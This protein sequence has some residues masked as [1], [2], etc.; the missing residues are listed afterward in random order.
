M[1]N[2]T[3]QFGTSRPDSRSIVKLSLTHHEPKRIPLDIGGTPRISGI[4]IQAYQL[5]RSKLGLAET[6]TRL[7]WQALHLQHPKI[8]EDFRTILKV[9]MESADPVPNGLQSAIHQDESGAQYYTDMFGIE[10]YMS[11]SAQYFDVRKSPLAKAETFQDVQSHR[12]PRGDEEF[13]LANLEKEAR[14]AWQEH[15]RAVVLG[16][17]SAGFF[18][19]CNFLIGY[20]K[21]LLSLALNPSL[22]EA[23]M[24]KLLEIKLN[25]YCAAIK[26][27]LA[28]G[29]EY[30]ICAETEDL[31]SQKGLLFSPQ[32]YRSLIKP[33]HKELFRSIKKYSQRKAFIELHSCGAIRELIPDMIESGV[34]IL[35]PIQVSAEGM[36]DTKKLKQDFGNELVFHGGGIDS[37]YTLPYGTPHEVRDEVRRR[38]DDL[39]PGGGFIF[40][41]VHSIQYNV[42]FENF[43]TMI[44]TYEKYAQ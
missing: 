41:P 43:M 18:E 23:V 16:R 5:F 7:R 9:D 38:I 24:D 37:Q 40:T 15:R 4:H 44:E 19:M 36:G 42:P 3:Q 34:E 25:Y 28:A 39:A 13:V 14:T 1:L 12:W 2:K 10:W 11:P 27:I 6:D 8:D 31:G 32:T 33:R 21:S 17:T 22:I 26:Q 20:E 35:N 29:L 30:F